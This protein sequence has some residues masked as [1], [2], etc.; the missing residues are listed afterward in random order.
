MTT[1]NN[2]DILE[3]LPLDDLL[4]LY[5]DVSEELTKVKSDG[6]AGEEQ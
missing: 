6:K 2:V 4:Q 3:N 1:A 5:V